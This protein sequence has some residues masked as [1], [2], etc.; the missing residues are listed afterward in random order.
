[1][2]LL[3]FASAAAAESTSGVGSETLALDNVS[4]VFTY[5]AGNERARAEVSPRYS[6][7]LGFSLMGAA[8][9]YITDRVAL[10][11]IVEYG[12]NKREYL[13]NAGIQFDDALSL[14]GTIGLLEEHQEYAEADGRTQVR[15][16]EYG[17][18]LRGAYDIGI[19][20]GFEVNGYS[21]SAAADQDSV[22]T[23]KLRGV[24]ILGDL[25]PTGNS[26]LK[27]GA[28][29]EWLDWNGA[30]GDRSGLTFSADAAQ[31][32]SETVGLSG[33]ARFGASEFVYGGGLTL[34][35]TDGGPTASA[36]GVSYSYVDGRDGI[37]DDQRIELSW[38]VGFG[39]RPA[40]RAASADPGGN[41]GI[42]GSRDD[43]VPRK[44]DLLGDVMK[45]PA[46]LP[47]RVVAKSAGAAAECSNFSFYGAGVGFIFMEVK[48]SGSGNSAV[49]RAIAA[50][51]KRPEV[52][53]GT[54]TDV[55][56][57]AI[58]EYFFD[59]RNSSANPL[60]ED[61]MLFLVNGD[62]SPTVANL[63]FNDGKVS[64]NCPGLVLTGG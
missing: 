3:L 7:S 40:V 10:G 16:M 6:E 59:S 23:G 43:H 18:S 30:S 57:Q 42:P 61:T 12:E 28:G 27:L 32:L 34:D 38:T 51:N 64:F 37:G 8:G 41:G 21:T 47:Q 46:F 56:G 53:A 60:A 25:A 36:V 19:L 24:Q 26:R 55:P 50:A 45:R 29:Y 49:A 9:A 63:S 17:A 52:W 1:M 4:P 62:T 2:A 22:E 39:T 5:A 31:Q 33:H 44:A 35:L 20:R 54:S 48:Y 11:L 58:T 15:Q 13:T 14:V